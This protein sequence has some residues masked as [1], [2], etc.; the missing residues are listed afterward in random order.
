MGKDEVKC[1]SEVVGCFS[2]IF[3]AAEAT[4][5]LVL[6]GLP[7]TTGQVIPHIYYFYIV[8]LI[9]TIYISALKQNPSIQILI[10]GM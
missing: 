2:A 1:K 5:S 7:V 6:K 10:K 8:H 3:S 4:N 9:S